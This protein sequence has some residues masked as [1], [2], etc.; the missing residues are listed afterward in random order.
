MPNENKPSRFAIGFSVVMLLSGA[1]F[2]LP[3]GIRGL[4]NAVRINNTLL[5][6]C[7]IFTIG[8]ALY[9]TVRDVVILKKRGVKGWVDVNT[10]LR[11]V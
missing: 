1:F 4:I 9:N 2:L 8:L 7:S 6:A 3:M 11:K 10:R 5:I